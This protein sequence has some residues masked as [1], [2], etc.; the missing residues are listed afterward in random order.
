M[1]IRLFSNPDFINFGTFIKIKLKALDS[2]NLCEPYGMNFILICC[3]KNEEIWIWKS[4]I[5]KAFNFYYRSVYSQ[6]LNLSNGT[7]QAH[8]NRAVSKVFLVKN[9]DHFLVYYACIGLL[10]LKILFHISAKWH[11]RE[12][13]IRVWSYVWI[14]V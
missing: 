2:M 7:E 13:E 5:F 3:P 10:S 6:A 1:H 11:L 4:L 14:C 12:A 8:L 9:T